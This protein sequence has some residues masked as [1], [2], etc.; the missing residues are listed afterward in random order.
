MA[1]IKYL[2]QSSRGSSA[3]Y[4]RLSLSRNSSFKRKIG[5]FINTKDWNQTKGLPIQNSPSTRELY[6]KLRKLKD[7][8]LDNINTANYKTETIDGD[9]LQYQIDL[10]FKRISTSNQ[11]ELVTDIIQN[12]INTAHLR[13]NSKGGVGL[14]Q[15]RITSYKRL[16]AL[17]HDF[18]GKNKYK[19]S[20]LNKKK[21][22]SF[23]RWLL[24]RTNYAPTYTFKK[25][26]DL[27]T[28]C[29]D[30]RSNGLETS[31]EL[32]D[33]KTKQISAYDDDMD[34]I[35]LTLTD[36]EK[37]EKAKLVDQSLINARKWLILA[38]FTGQRGK[39][40]TKRVNTQ[41]FEK[42]GND[43]IIRLIQK[44][45]NKSV[46]IPVLPKVKEIYENGFPYYV[47]IQKLNKYFKKIGKIA[48]VNDMVMGR[49]QDPI[50]KRGV[51]K[52]R[53]KYEYISSH[54]GRRSFASNHYGKLPTSIIRLVTGHSK[55]SSLRIYVNQSEDIHI[56]PFLDFY[57]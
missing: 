19:I 13:D 15:S 4:L 45:G 36:I 20:E 32:N 49:L 47:S 50:T 43:L 1:T 44:K 7:V 2:L 14:S 21:F 53:P 40:L 55:E 9:W 6:S 33:I 28:V 10:Y 23:K 52:L 24:E 25:L 46:L 54:I 37:I 51:K 22:E 35:F 17:F 8:I 3:I 38:C 39:S 34:V 41:S 57:K 29:K 11:S 30:A 48:E 16:K 27:K 5:L 26:S 18:E 42:Y 56:K 31:S 12:I